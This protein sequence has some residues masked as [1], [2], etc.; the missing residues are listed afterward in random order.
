M[1]RLHEDLNKITQRIPI[2][3]QNNDNLSDYEAARKAWNM[4]V[5]LNKSKIVDLFHVIYFF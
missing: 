2:A 1:D 3:E 5:K 4:H